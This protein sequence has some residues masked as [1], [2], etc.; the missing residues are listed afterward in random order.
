MFVIH[1]LA[2]ALS[3]ACDSPLIFPYTMLCLCLN[4]SSQP[5]LHTKSLQIYWLMPSG[6]FYRLENRNFFRSWTTEV[7][8]HPHR[9]DGMFEFFSRVT[10]SSNDDKILFFKNVDTLD[11]LK[12]YFLQTSTFFTSSLIA[13]IISTL[14]LMVR[15]FLFLVDRRKGWFTNAKAM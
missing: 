2:L 9:S 1:S 7:V 12:P 8:L 10:F 14:S 5:L 13:C 6:W 3:S 15:H 11:E 4:R